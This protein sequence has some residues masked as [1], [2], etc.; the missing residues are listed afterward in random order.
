MDPQPVSL[1]EGSAAEVAGE[2]PVALVHAARVLQVLVSVVLVGEH[3][4][5]PVALETLT[6]IWREQ[7]HN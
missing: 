7:R 2:L 6:G 5:A 1:L 3:L 4:P